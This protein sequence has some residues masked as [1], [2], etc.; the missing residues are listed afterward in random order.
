MSNVVPTYVFGIDPR[1]IVFESY[2]L[3]PGD[4]RPMDQSNLASA[5]RL[6]LDEAG[7]DWAVP[8]TFRRTVA[9]MLHRAGV[10]L[11]R[12]ADQLGHSDPSMTAKVYLGGD[13]A[14]DKSDLAAL[15]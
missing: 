2:S 5:V 4:N 14:G 6:C 15:L 12:I 3:F 11:S 9:T 8:H 1:E 10:P 13:P 7:L